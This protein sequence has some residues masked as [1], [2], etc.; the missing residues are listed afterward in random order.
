MVLRELAPVLLLF[1]RHI[2]RRGLQ[3]RVTEQ[4]L[5]DVDRLAGGHRQHA[6]HV[7]WRTAR[8]EGH[9]SWRRSA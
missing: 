3:R 2:H 6:A 1:C 4:P 8:G 5:H 7:M 9:A